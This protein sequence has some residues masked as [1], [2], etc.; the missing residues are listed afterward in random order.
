MNNNCLT[1]LV[2]GDSISVDQTNFNG[3][4]I[5]I[6]NYLRD[7]KGK[8]VKYINRA[9][10]GWS[11]FGMYTSIGWCG[12]YD[13]DIAI[14]AI[15]INDANDGAYTSTFDT[16][17]QA[18]INKLRLRNSKIDIILC[19]PTRPTD[20]TRVANLPAYRNAIT[21][22]ATENNC[23]CCHFENAWTQPNA[24]TYTQDALHPTAAGHLLMYNLLTPI[25]DKIMED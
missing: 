23:Y 7:I 4:G 1:L 5:L 16:Y 11:A 9:I 22:I 13:A 25:I 19:C 18:I 17:I 10:S 6:R 14:I 2:I 3:Y 20:T 12:N 21:N 8:S 15:G 24:A